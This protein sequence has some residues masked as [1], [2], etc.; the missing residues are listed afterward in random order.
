MHRQRWISSLTA[1]DAVRSEW[2]GQCALLHPKPFM[3][4]T[5]PPKNSKTV[6]RS[7]FSSSVTPPALRGTERLTL[8]GGTHGTADCH[9][10]ICTCSRRSTGARVGTP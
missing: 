2:S 8:G 10:G 5:E 3:C 9:S 7:G 1:A 4:G 6:S